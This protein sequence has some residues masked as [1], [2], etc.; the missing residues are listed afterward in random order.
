MT[1]ARRKYQRRFAR[2][3]A[4]SRSMDLARQARITVSA[5]DRSKKA[6]R[7]LT[8]WESAPNRLDIRGVDTRR[9]GRGMRTRPAR[10]VKR[11]LSQRRPQAPV[12]AVVRKARPAPTVRRAPSADVRFT[13]APGVPKKTTALIREYLAAVQ[14]GKPIPKELQKRAREDEF[15]ADKGV[16]LTPPGRLSP[17]PIWHDPDAP[18]RAKP[19]PG[20]ITV[21]FDGKQ[22]DWLGMSARERRKML[23]SAPAASRPRKGTATRSV[24]A[25]AW[26]EL[27]QFRPQLTRDAFRKAQAAMRTVMKRVE[28]QG[29]MTVTEDQR[30]AALATIRR[31]FGEEM[32]RRHKDF[33]PAWGRRRGTL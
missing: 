18:P 23:R 15:L 1:T 8:R 5:S 33:G 27:R 16:T 13:P 32:K 12:E 31:E 22:V 6:R 11:R 19:G 2:R 30:R 20:D 7:L 28:D 26:R 14:S 3:S 24:Q 4:R 9:R 17:K 29:E 10:R 21:R 25:E